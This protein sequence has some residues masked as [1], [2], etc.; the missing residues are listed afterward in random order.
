MAKSEAAGRPNV[1]LITVDQWPGPLLGDAGHPVILTP[2]IDAA[3][4]AWA[5][6]T[7]GPTA[8]ARSASRRVAR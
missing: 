7:T 5:C 8:S 3:G 2:T 1:L 6:A 4:R